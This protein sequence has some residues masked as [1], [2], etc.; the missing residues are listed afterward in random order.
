MWKLY[1]RQSRDK[2]KDSDEEPFT[3][4]E[5]AEINDMDVLVKTDVLL[6]NLQ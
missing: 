2:G 1:A 4:L 5:E 6:V 3:D